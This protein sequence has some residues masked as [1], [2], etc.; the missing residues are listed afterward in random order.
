MDSRGIPI[1][2]PGNTLPSSPKRTKKPIRRE[3]PSSPYFVSAL[4][5]EQSL[6][7]IYDSFAEACFNSHY[8][9]SFINDDCRYNIQE[10]Q[11]TELFPNDTTLQPSTPK[12]F[13]S[14]NDSE[15]S[16]NE[17]K[18]P[19]LQ[20]SRMSMFHSQQSQ[21]SEF[22]NYESEYT[23][24]LI[25]VAPNVQIRQ[26]VTTKDSLMNDSEGPSF[27]SYAMDI[28]SVNEDQAQ[29]DVDIT[30]N[31]IPNQAEASQHINLEASTH[32]VDFPKMNSDQEFNVT[33]KSDK[34]IQESR[35]SI[36]I[37]NNVIPIEDNSS[38][39]DTRP[40]S[41]LI[42][43]DTAH[44]TDNAQPFSPINCNNTTTDHKLNTESEQIATKLH[45]ETEQ[46]AVES[47]VE[48]EQIAIVESTQESTHC[49][50]EESKNSVLF[51]EESQAADTKDDAAQSSTVELP[52]R[53]TRGLPKS[54]KA[55]PSP[56][57]IRAKPTIPVSSS[58]ILDI[59]PKAIPNHT[60]DALLDLTP[61]VIPTP[62]P[63]RRSAR[64][65]A[66]TVTPPPPAPK[67]TTRARKSA[68]QTDKDTTVQDQPP[69][70]KKPKRLTKR[71]ILAEEIRIMEQESQAVEIST[72]EPEKEKYLTVTDQDIKKVAQRELY[73]ELR[74]AR[75]EEE[76]N[77]INQEFPALRESYELIERA[78]RGMDSFISSC[79]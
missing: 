42:Y 68:T 43:L 8:N 13:K 62:T 64:V 9:H 22:M 33:E 24:D 51:I 28:S 36:S 23:E 75:D 30:M 40:G 48:S 19:E 46:A 10:F 26:S 77:R 60:P 56:R 52:K 53:A 2:I 34:D 38:K 32:D 5:N 74:I 55:A 78:G 27:N 15:I 3:I 20:A 29:L 39:V 79:E 70:F 69:K 45:L 76:I 65:K 14:V 63:T 4:K 59:V 31:D 37:G 49:S 18:V 72:S 1:V 12:R 16:L 73:N 25:Q 66:T 35:G 17:S 54:T 47:L 50:L 6:L 11:K 7:E 41:E 71:Q 67:R 58:T 44:T 61:S 21:P 57:K